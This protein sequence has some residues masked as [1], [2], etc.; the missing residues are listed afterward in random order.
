[1]TDLSAGWYSSHA[2]ELTVLEAQYGVPVDAAAIGS[3]LC[4]STVTLS[5]HRYFFYILYKKAKLSRAF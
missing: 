3:T 2:A 5:A 1:M 4:A